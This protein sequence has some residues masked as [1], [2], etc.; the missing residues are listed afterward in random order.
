M[1]SHLEGLIDLG[2]EVGTMLVIRRKFLFVAHSLTWGWLTE[3][4]AFRCHDRTSGIWATSFEPRKPIFLV[5]RTWRVLH[6]LAFL[7]LWIF[8][9]LWLVFQILM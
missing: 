4:E 3:K 5:S 7:F 1:V 6:M 2:I 8:N 9:Y